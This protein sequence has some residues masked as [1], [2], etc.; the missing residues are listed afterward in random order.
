MPFIDKNIN[1]FG[2]SGEWPNE[3]SPPAAG[4][5]TQPNPLRVLIS[6]AILLISIICA[7]LYHLNTIFCDSLHLEIHLSVLF[8]YDIPTFKAGWMYAKSSPNALAT[9]N[10]PSFKFYCFLV[11]VYH[12]LFLGCNDHLPSYHNLLLGCNDHLPKWWFMWFF[13]ISWIWVL[14]LVALNPLTAEGI[15]RN[16]SIESVC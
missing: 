13:S 9:K 15:G 12:N 5:L 6:Q 1:I 2:T 16:I 7:W 3:P 14:S 8:V 11:T 4:K 10:L